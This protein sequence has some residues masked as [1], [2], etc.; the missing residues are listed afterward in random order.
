VV[1]DVDVGLDDA[2]MLPEPEP[3]IPDVP[4]VSSIPEDVDIAGDVD[5]PALDGVATPEIARVPGSIAVAGVE[6]PAVVPPPSYIALDPYIS[7]GEMATVEHAVPLLVVGM[8][9][10][11]AKPVGAGLTPADVI[12]VEPNGIPVG[13]PAEPNPMPSGEV[14]P[15][16]GVGVTESSTCAIAAALQPISA[17]RTAAINDDFMVILLPK[18]APPPD[19]LNAIRG[20]DPGSGGPS[21]KRRRRCFY[22]K[23]S[24]GFLHLLERAHFDLPNTFTR[25]VEFCRKLFERQWFFGQMSRL[26]NATFAVIQYIDRSDQRLM[27]VAFLVLFDDDSFRRGRLINEMVLPFADFIVLVNRSINRFVAAEAPIHVDDIFVRNIE[28]LCDQ[29]NLIGAQIT[30]FQCR[31]LALCRAQFEKQLPL[32]R[33]SADFHERP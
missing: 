1:G 3:H 4:E 18:S 29:G 15:I 30:A 23:V 26:E 9:M 33:G 21:R 20:S 2:A 16:V 28:R 6:T 32:V 10:V 17:E 24:G 8:E 11:P 27:L 13:E 14:T 31:D 22:N 12:S 7:A 19:A 5:V 25:Y